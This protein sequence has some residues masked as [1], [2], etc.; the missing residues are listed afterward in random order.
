MFVFQQLW[1]LLLLNVCFPT[2][3][4][5]EDLTGL[6]LSNA[7]IVCCSFSQTVHALNSSTTLVWS[8]CL[9]APCSVLHL[10]QTVISCVPIIGQ[11]WRRTAALV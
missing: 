9:D 6:A 7:D 4:I 8:I 11:I 10:Q 3:V 5:Q 2:A 1:P